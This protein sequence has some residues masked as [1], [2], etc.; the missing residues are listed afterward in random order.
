MSYVNSCVDYLSI[1]IEDLITSVLKDDILFYLWLSIYSLR[2][3]LV[4]EKKRTTI[5]SLQLCSTGMYAECSGSLAGQM[6]A[7]R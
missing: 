1:F 2:T 6:W 5:D 7:T 3:Y 4:L